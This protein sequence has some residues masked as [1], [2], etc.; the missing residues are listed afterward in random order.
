[1]SWP[2]IIMLNMQSPAWHFKFTR[3][4]VLFSL[5]PERVREREDFRS[6]DLVVYYGLRLHLCSNNWMCEARPLVPH[7][8]HCQRY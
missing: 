5:H 4:L 8:A 7:T 1:M 3:N 6:Q 2:L